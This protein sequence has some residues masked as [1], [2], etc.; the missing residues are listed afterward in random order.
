M[1]GAVGD[2]KKNVPKVVGVPQLYPLRS[3]ID[4][5]LK[6]DGRVFGNKK[7]YLIRI[8]SCFF[9]G[10]G[11]NT[12]VEAKRSFGDLRT[13]YTI[14]PSPPRSSVAPGEVRSCSGRTPSLRL[15]IEHC[16]SRETFELALLGRH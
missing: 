5:F 3:L 11:P 10:I 13:V 7:M 16:L 1:T 4:N 2:L 8:W 15:K 14:T 9:G 12:V 6:T